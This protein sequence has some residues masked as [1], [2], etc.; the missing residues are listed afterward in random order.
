MTPR[1]EFVERLNRQLMSSQS[2]VQNRRQH[3][4]RQ[5]KTRDNLMMGAATVLGVAVIF[6]MG[7]RVAITLLGSL[8]LFAQLFSRK[9]AHKQAP[10]Q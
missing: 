5:Q 10:I 6:T 7:I 3:I 2:L 9:G 8:S 4:E 1:P